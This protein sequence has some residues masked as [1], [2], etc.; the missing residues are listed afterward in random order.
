[1]PE[2]WGLHEFEPP[3]FTA[4]DVRPPWYAEACPYALGV[5]AAPGDGEDVF[6]LERLAAI[7]RLLT[8]AEGPRASAYL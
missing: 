7:S 5:D 3:H 4:P 8:T 6:N 2:R 1:V